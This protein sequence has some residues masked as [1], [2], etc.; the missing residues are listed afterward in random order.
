MTARTER[1][2]ELVKQI[3]QLTGEGVTV[4]D[5]P[6]DIP[7]ALAAGRPVV[8]LMPPN[9]KFPTYHL[10]EAEWEAYVIAGPYADMRRAW[11]TIDGL[12][13]ELAGPL[14]VDTARTATFAHPG[15]PEYP[16]YVLTFSESN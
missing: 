12:I 16:A 2:A 10:T 7:A 14:S 5:D 8:A 4:T 11:K 15:M 3:A 9:L 13:S 6:L 1:A